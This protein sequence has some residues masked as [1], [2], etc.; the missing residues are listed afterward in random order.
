MASRPGSEATRFSP[1][2][3]TEQADQKGP[4]ARR[5][6]RAAREAYS[7][8]VERAAAGANEADGPF[9]SAC[10]KLHVDREA[11]VDVAR[12]PDAAAVVGHDGAADRQAHAEPVGLGAHEALED[13]LEVLVLH[14]DAGVAHRQLDHVGSRGGGDR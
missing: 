10:G 2:P 7:V 12:R 4:D 5:R 14:A 9:S 13:A 1:W 6:P 11:V 8:Y 3:A